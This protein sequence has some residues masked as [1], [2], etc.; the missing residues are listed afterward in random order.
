MWSGR[1]SEQVKVGETVR[2][3]EFKVISC[4]NQAPVISGINNTSQFQIQYLY[5]LKLMFYNESTDP[6]GA[7]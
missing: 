1:I 5:W 7:G 6:D 2:D 4:S 3:M